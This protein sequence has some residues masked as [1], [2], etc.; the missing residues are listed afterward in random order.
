M[1]PLVT[2]DTELKLT[3]PLNLRSALAVETW[4]SE[5]AEFEIRLGWWRVGLWSVSSLQGRSCKRSAASV[6]CCESR[7]RRSVEDGG[8]SAC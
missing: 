5:V 2:T 1:L 8:Q 6:T 3:P 4:P 7:D